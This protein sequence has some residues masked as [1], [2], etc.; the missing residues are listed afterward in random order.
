MVKVYKKFTKNTTSWENICIHNGSLIS[1]T[2]RALRNDGEKINNPP[3]PKKKKRT[4][5]YYEYVIHREGETQMF[6]KHRKDSLIHN[7]KYRSKPAEITIFWL[8][9]WENS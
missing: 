7:K 9:I 1:K 6:L 8:S 4:G 5:K 3:P 2:Q